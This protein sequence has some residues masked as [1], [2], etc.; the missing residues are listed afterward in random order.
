MAKVRRQNVVLTIEDDEIQH[1][2]SLGYKVIDN[3]GNVI[4]G[5]EPD[6]KQLYFQE[7]AKNLALEEELKKLKAPA[8]KPVEKP[9]DEPKPETEEKPKPKRR[10]RKSQNG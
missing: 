4:A 3:M 10:S 8:E 2:L 5:E 6:Y 9:V 7:K 1:Y